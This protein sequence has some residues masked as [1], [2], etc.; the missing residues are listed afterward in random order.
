MLFHFITVNGCDLSA[1]ISNKHNYDWYDLHAY[2][3]DKFHQFTCC[4]AVFRF[5]V[6]ASHVV[7]SSSRPEVTSPMTPLMTT[8]P[9]TSPT[10]PVLTVTGS[11]SW[12]QSPVPTDDPL[13]SAYRTPSP[14]LGQWDLLS[15]ARHSIERLTRREEL[16]ATKV[17]WCDGTCLNFWHATNSCCITSG[18][19]RHVIGR[20][21]Q[22]LSSLF[23]LLQYISN[24]IILLRGSGR[25]LFL[26]SSTRCLS[27]E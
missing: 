9:M 6:G 26:T 15:L 1:V 22:S 19:K 3:V 14:L 13:F 11:G 8:S 12:L 25:E 16:H 10:R 5:S 20:R 21:G 18:C 2:Y 27:N 4:N 7:T 24:S 17:M 23:A